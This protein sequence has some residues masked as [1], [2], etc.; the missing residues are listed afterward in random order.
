MN[1]IKYTCLKE[2]KIG[3]LNLG[4]FYISSLV[5]YINTLLTFKCP[6]LHTFHHF[7]DHVRW[8]RLFC[9][10]IRVGN[11]THNTL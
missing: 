8:E 4:L 11:R 7:Q 3:P 2:E 10:N 6:C 1:E 5:S 9:I